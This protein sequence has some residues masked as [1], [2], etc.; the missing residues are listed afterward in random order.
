MELKTEIFVIVNPAS[1]G[2]RAARAQR[3]V[4]KMVPARG[5]TAQFVHSQ[6]ADDIREHAARAAASGIPYVVAMGGDGTLHYV[7]EG[8]LGTRAAAGFFPAGN[9]N[10]IARALGIPSDPI[11]AAQVFFDGNTRAVDVIR[12]KFAEGQQTHFTGAGGLGLDAAAAELANSRFRKWPG[13]TRYLAGTFQAFFREPPMEASAEIDG[14]AWHGRILFAAIANGSFYGS[15]IRIAPDAKVDD[16][17]MDVAIVGE[18]RL[19][20]LLKAIPI[21]LTSGDLRNFPEVQRF[22]CRRIALRTE[23]EARVHGDGEALGESPAEF[24]V[25][26][27]ALK[28]VAPQ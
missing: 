26:P 4:E 16:G 18:V 14:V 25:L 6:N 11:A 15:G 13:V 28:I 5:C 19:P 3:A 22:R 27:G 8:V 12:V 2:G 17:W 23:R 20:R 9:G 21:V 10:D 7:V 1:G 24:E